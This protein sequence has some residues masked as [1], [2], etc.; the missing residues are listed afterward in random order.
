MLRSLFPSANHTSTSVEDR[1]VTLQVRASMLFSSVKSSERERERQRRR[2]LCSSSFLS[3]NTRPP[4]KKKTVSQV[5]KRVFPNVSPSLRRELW[6]SVLQRS[7]AASR[8]AAAYPSLLSS[9]LAGEKETG[10]EGRDGGETAGGGEGEE[11]EPEG[12]GGGARA[13][14]KAAAGTVPPEVVDAIRRD[15]GRTFPSIAGFEP[16]EAAASAAGGKG[17]GGPGRRARSLANV[18]TAYAAF[19][20]SVSYCQGMNFLGGLLLLYLDDGGGDDSDGATPAFDA[21]GGEEESLAGADSAER[22]AF[23]LLTH[24]LMNKGLRSLFTEGMEAL[25]AR[26]SHLHL[27]LP[28]GIKKLFDE[29]LGLSVTLFA[30]PWF[31][32]AFASDFPVSVSARLVDA[33]LTTPAAVD[34]PLLRLAAACVRASRKELLAAR[35]AE[36]AVKVLRKTLPSKKV[37]RLHDLV[38]EAFEREWGAEELAVLSSERPRLT[39]DEGQ[40]GEGEGVSSSSLSS[41]SLPFEEDKAPSSRGSSPS[42]AAR[43]EKHQQEH[44]QHRKLKWEDAL[45]ARRAASA[46]REAGGGPGAEAAAAGAEEEEDELGGSSS[47]RGG[48]G[49]GDLLEVPLPLPHLPPAAAAAAAAEASAPRGGSPTPAAAAAAAEEALAELLSCRLELDSPSSSSSFSAPPSPSPA[50]AAAT[51]ITTAT[52]AAA[53]RAPPLSSDSLWTS[54]RKAA[55]LEPAEKREGE[56]RDASASASSSAAASAA[57]AAARER[58]AAE[59]EGWSSFQRSASLTAPPEGE[60]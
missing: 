59:L 55:D 9:A 23:G 4:L 50:T 44:R 19:D 18:L 35:D 32:T 57:A 29:E 14:A 16:E 51:T 47:S 12:G 58:A 37:S 22:A 48:G 45:L 3:L 28:P 8:A 40:Q 46:D 52:A 6:L 2:L 1:L 38:S 31:M 42:A 10:G 36:A 24:L 15:V 13:T 53:R 34:R 39:R 17:G 41:S 30:A 21:D 49:G 56:A 20:P 43:S 33:M 25:T 60:K 5:G 11:A 27:L 26:L 54:S 7:R